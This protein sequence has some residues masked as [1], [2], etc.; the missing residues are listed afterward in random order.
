M[1]S[2]LTSLPPQQSSTIRQNWRARPAIRA[3]SLSCSTRVTATAA[4]VSRF[5][6]SHGRCEENCFGKGRGSHRRRGPCLVASS[7]VVVRR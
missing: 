5:F 1:F 3:A 4:S 2:N 7:A 6:G